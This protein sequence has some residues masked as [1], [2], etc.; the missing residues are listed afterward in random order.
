MKVLYTVSNPYGLGADRW[1][2][3]GYKDAFEQEGHEFFTLS[4]FD[5]FKKTVLQVK[6]NLFLL[7]F[8]F[9]ERFASDVA[10]EFFA[11]IKKEGTKIFCLAD[12]GIDKEVQQEG[13]IEF[14]KKYLPFFDICYSNY[15]PETTGRFQELFGVP[16]HFIP[17][18]ANT[19]YYF[20]DSP[21]PKFSCD[22]AF[23]GSFY[24]QKR[25]QYEKLLF[26]L[27]RKYKVLIYGAGWTKR[28][29][30]L[31]LVGGLA[32][33]AKLAPLA[34]LISR[35]RILLSPDEERKLYASAKI[36]VNIH[37]YYK[38]GTVKGF[39]NERE[40][41]VPASGG[42]QLS[43]YIP[44]IERYFKLGEEI[45]VAKSPEE[46]FSK[47]DYY[48]THEKERKEIQQRGTERVLNEH[49]YRHRVRQM[50]EPY[51]NF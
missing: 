44:G 24:T 45:V 39:S 29:R 20:P 21:G 16:M 50:M 7:D 33:R 3:E 36:C 9:F 12:V 10:P 4:E 8:A 27:F 14:F 49:T 15:A 37:E 30:I 22:I 31:R 25:E 6:P 47:I 19:K 51:K 2:W 46:W 41:K 35:Q 1:I 11:Q 17:H 23:V 48:L 42:F 34:K 32:R 13:R 18:A 38:D 40:F 43:D 26:P 28:D 5:D